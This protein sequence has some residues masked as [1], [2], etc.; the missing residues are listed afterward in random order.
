MKLCTPAVNTLFLL[1]HVKNEREKKRERVCLCEKQRHKETQ[2][3]KE[4]KYILEIQ[5]IK[6][7]KI[8]NKKQKGASKK[9]RKP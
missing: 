3:R 4:K 7:I 9:K 1:L 5:N 8:I 6:N 2:I